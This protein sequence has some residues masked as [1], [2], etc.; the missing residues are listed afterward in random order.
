MPVS[1]FAV[2][3][4]GAQKNVAPSGVTVAIVNKDLL[5]QSKVDKLRVFH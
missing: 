2:I 3:Y 5:D 4:A 1:K